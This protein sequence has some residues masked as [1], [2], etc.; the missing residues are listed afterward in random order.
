MQLGD[1]DTDQ[2]RSEDV[3]AICL[4]LYFPFLKHDLLDFRET[5]DEIETSVSET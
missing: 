1:W 2:R 4:V 5:F 3:A